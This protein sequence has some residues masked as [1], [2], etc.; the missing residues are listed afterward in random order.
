[1]HDDVPAHTC[2]KCGSNLWDTE[3]AAGRWVCDGCEHL[4]F[5]RLRDEVPAFSRNLER[6]GALMKGSSGS[7]NIG[8]ASREIPA[9]LRIGTL[10]SPPMGA[11]SPSSGHRGR[12]A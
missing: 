3:I 10:L 7:G 6:L 2:T 5:Q 8:G 4:A 12:L 11:S 1:M 9:P